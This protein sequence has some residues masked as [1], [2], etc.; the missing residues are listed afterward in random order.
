MRAAREAT[1]RRSAIL[2]KLLPHSDNHSGLPC[3]SSNRKRAACASPR[4]SEKPIT[5]RMRTLRSSP[6]V[7]TSPSLTLWPGAVSRTPLMRTWPDS[8]SAAA[9]VR[10][11]TTRACHNHLSSRWRSVRSILLLT[12]FLHANRLPLRLK[13][14]VLAVGGELFLQRRELGKG[15]IRI[16]GTLTLARRARRIGPVRWAEVTLVAAAFVAAMVARSPLSVAAELALV[17]VAV[18]VLAEAFART[19]AVVASPSLLAVVASLTRLR[20]LR[21]S[22][23]LRRRVAVGLAEIAPAMM[24]VMA[25]LLA[26]LALAGFARR[27][28]ARLGALLMAMMTV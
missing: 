16:D 24:A 22:G 23:H 4:R 11:F 17:L 2:S 14:L 27:L 13:T 7:S 1:A 10:A 6:M 12:R 15:R 19:L 18:L 5:L 8:T 25:A 21:A 26:L 3:K 28:I 20:A 9:L